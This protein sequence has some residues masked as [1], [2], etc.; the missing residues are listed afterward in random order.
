M[1]PTRPAAPGLFQIRRIK[2]FREPIVDRCEQLI[3]LGA[4]TLGLPTLGLPKPRKVHRGAQLPGFGLLLTSPNRV[5]RCKLARR[6]GVERIGLRADPQSPGE[7]L[8]SNVL[9]S[10]DFHRLLGCQASRPRIQVLQLGHYLICN[11]LER[12]PQPNWA[13]SGRKYS[14]IIRP[15]WEPTDNRIASSSVSAT[16]ISRTKRHSLR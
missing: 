14:R 1:N 13:S 10:S 6:P 16:K 12:V 7:L 2:S 15:M 9:C 5:S 11:Q 3:S 4:L 8:H